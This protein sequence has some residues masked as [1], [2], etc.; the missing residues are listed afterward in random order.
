MIKIDD[1]KINEIAQNLDCG[2]NCFFNINTGELIDLPENYEDIDDEDA[3]EM[4][5]DILEKIEDPDFKKIPV[6][7]SYESFQIMKSFVEKVE[8]KAFE[9]KLQSALDGKRPFANFKNCVDNSDFRES[10][11]AHKQEELEKYVR[12]Q[13]QF[14]EDENDDKI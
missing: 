10:W 9:A 8:N 13:I 3:V 6:L 12:E 1:I 14:I 7:E 11:F 5:G 2:M 4:F